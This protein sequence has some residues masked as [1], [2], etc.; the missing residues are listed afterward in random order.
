MEILTQALRAATIDCQDFLKQGLNFKRQ[1]PETLDLKENE[2]QGVESDTVMST[3][4][5]EDAD[6]RGLEENRKCE[7]P[8]EQSF[9]LDAALFAKLSVSD[10]WQD[11]A[12]LKND[13]PRENMDQISVSPWVL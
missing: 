3:I 8:S 4:S 12:P 5:S 13:L 11:W 6:Q 10:R 2:L 7:A 1:L 9:I